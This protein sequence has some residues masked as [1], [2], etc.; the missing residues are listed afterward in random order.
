MS[1]ST[2][3]K[4]W[5]STV[6]IQISESMVG[7]AIRTRDWMF[8]VHDPEGKGSEDPLS[9]NYVDFAM[10]QLGSDPYQKLNLIGRPEYKEIANQL[11]EELKRRI[12]ANG[13][14]EPTIKAIRYFV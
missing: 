9:R 7:R 14:P 1:E 6:Y 10:Y 8:S 12:V 2:A 3:R 11:R 5:D 4:A 13:E